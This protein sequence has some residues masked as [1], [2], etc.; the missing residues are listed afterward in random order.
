MNVQVKPETVQKKA[1]KLKAVDPKAAEPK[2]PMILVFGKPGVG[3]TWTSLDFPSVYFIDTEGGANRDHYTSKLKAS[4]GMYMG[5]EQGSQD[6]D[7]IIDQIKALATEEH[8]FKTFILDSG[9]KP[10]NMEVSK[11]AERL[12][13]KDAFG[14]SKKPAIKHMRRLLGWLNRLDMNVIITAF[15]KPLWANGE[16]TGVTFDL[17]DHQ[18]EH[19]LDLCLHIKKVADKHL[20][21]PRKS[22][23]I[24]FPEGVAFPWSYEEFASRYGRDVIERKST[25]ITLASPEQVAEA[26]KLLG[27]VKLNETDK[28]DKW[29]LDN[30]E[31]FAEVDSEKM[32]KIL[33]HLKSKIA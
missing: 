21:V 17:W 24:G 33:A 32:T 25:Q 31:L 10:F 12:G 3:K 5:P 29:I 7:T 15:E 23:L 14:A 11:E 13:D 16:Q 18:L 22:R 26:I 6:F 4:G 9:S 30:Q 27:V 1:S 19:E 20:A 8:Q 2:K 28:Q